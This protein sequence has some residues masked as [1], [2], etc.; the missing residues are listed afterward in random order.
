MLFWLGCAGRVLEESAEIPRDT[1]QSKVVLIM[2]G[3]FLKMMPKRQFFLRPS[4]SSLEKSL[5]T[6]SFRSS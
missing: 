6:D 5:L 3:P 4:L 2:H 1:L